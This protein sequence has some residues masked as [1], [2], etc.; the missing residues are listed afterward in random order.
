MTL[1]PRGRTHKG[2][3]PQP[4][5]PQGVKVPEP[6]PP[7]STSVAPTRAPSSLGRA[8]A[9]SE[10]RQTHLPFGSMLCSAQFSSASS[11]FPPSLLPLP[12]APLPPPPP[13]SSPSFP[14]QLPLPT[15]LSTCQLPT[16]PSQLSARFYIEAWPPRPCACVAGSP[17]LEAGTRSSH[18]SGPPSSRALRRS[19]PQ[20]A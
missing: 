1:P 10:D 7:T 4:Q 14:S 19:Q 13:A 20:D 11:S 3:S 9:L 8:G 2:L 12:T 6:P 18:L 17:L 15:C 16:A 5:S